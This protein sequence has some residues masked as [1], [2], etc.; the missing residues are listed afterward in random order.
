MNKHDSS[1]INMTIDEQLHENSQPLLL[2]FQRKDFKEFPSRSEFVN[3]KAESHNNDQSRIRSFLS[4][5]VLQ[6]YS[7]FDA[8]ELNWVY[9]KMLQMRFIRDNIYDLLRNLEKID[10]NVYTKESLLNFLIDIYM[11]KYPNDKDLSIK[12]TGSEILKNKRFGTFKLDISSTQKSN[13]SFKRYEASEIKISKISKITQVLSPKCSICLMDFDISTTKVES[14][15]H[16]F[17]TECLNSYIKFQI[18]SGK[19]NQIKC[20][21]ENCLNLLSDLFLKNFITNSVLLKY[22]KFK[23]DWEILSD[24]NKKWCIRPNCQNWIEKIPGQTTNRMVCQCGQEF[25][26]LCNNAWHEGKTCDE[27][28]DEDYLKYETEVVVKHCPKCDWKIEKNEGCNHIHCRCGHH[29]CWLCRSNYVNGF[30][31]KN[32][33]KFPNQQNHHLLPDVEWQLAVMR[34]EETQ[35]WAWFVDRQSG[36]GK[37]KYIVAFIISLVFF[38]FIFLLIFYGTILFGILIEPFLK[39][40][41]IILHEDDYPIDLDL[42]CNN[43]ENGCYVVAFIPFLLFLNV[44]FVVIYALSEIGFYIGKHVFTNFMKFYIMLDRNNNIFC[45]FENVKYLMKR[46]IPE[47]LGPDDQGLNGVKLLSVVS[48]FSMICLHVLI[49][50]AILKSSL[51]LN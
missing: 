37:L 41:R 40:K 18:N 39:I 49:V 20:P 3:F 32:C 28:I 29:F 47:P 16:K 4:L 43:F 11:N 5:S 45:V 30:C 44:L 1:S 50:M 38:P 13:F 51:D 2:S 14:C 7:N 33:P 35:K 12:T 25:C 46:N 34:F 6:K 10:L 42:Q 22:E 17:C 15:S 19:V 23:L 48:C 31:V 21:N 27:A 9:N 36:V 26:F 24:R 8:T